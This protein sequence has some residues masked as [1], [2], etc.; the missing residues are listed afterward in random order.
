[1][2]ILRAYAS[3]SQAHRLGVAIF[4]YSV[5]G[6][7]AL[8]RIRAG[9]ATMPGWLRAFVNVNP[10]SH[11]V[12]AERALMNGTP[13]TTEAAWVLLTSAVLIAIFGPLTM[14]LHRADL[15]RG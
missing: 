7:P 13:A 5:R 2:R 3:G 15:G 12:T 6:I 11:L 8:C 10:V 14:R 4:G 9:P 1:V